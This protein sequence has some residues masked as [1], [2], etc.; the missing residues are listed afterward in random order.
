MNRK[1]LLSI[2][3]ALVILSGSFVS[4]SAAQTPS[5]STDQR[6]LDQDVAL[7]RKDIRSQKKQIVAANMQLT[8]KEAEK[9]WPLF[10]QYTDELMKI[11]NAKYDAIKQYATNFDTLS[12]DQAVAL[13]RQ[14]LG[15]DEQVAQLRMKYIPIFGKVISGKKTALFLQLDRRLVMLIDLQ[16]AA[17]IP[18]IQP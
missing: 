11:N 7:L 9:F 1:N 6:S 12:D 16:L 17:Q 13:A 10:E 3:M 8:D 4:Q 18:M 15:V 5:N 2:G 14:L